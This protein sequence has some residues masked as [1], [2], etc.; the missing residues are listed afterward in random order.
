M[1][2]FFPFILPIGLFNH[3]L[4]FRN[5]HFIS[6]LFCS[7]MLF[8]YYYVIYIEKEAKNKYALRQRF[9]A[10]QQYVFLFLLF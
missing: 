7:I 5:V 2:K 4:F 6:S 3:I 8:I 10:T 1:S 9:L